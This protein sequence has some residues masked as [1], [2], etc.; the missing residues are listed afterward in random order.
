MK[1]NAVRQLQQSQYS[2]HGDPRPEAAPA[3]AAYWQL[4]L[5]AAF[6]VLTSLPQAAHAGLPD[7]EGKVNDI[8]TWLQAA[9][10]ALFTAGIMWAGY[11]M[12]FAG[13]QFR[14]VSNI[15][16][17]GVLAGG[18]AAFAAWLFS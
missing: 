8:V 6:L 15:L 5:L 7:L 17:G 13:A 11:R 14:D 12:V 3:R 2:V 4:A 1:V 18:A 10:I 9:G 16:W